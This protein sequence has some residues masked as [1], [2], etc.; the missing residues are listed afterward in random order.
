MLSASSGPD[1]GVLKIC[2][3]AVIEDNSSKHNIA[4]FFISLQN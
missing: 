2:E 4:P 1:V 3:K